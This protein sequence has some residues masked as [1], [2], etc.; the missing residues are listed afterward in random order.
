MSKLRYFYMESFGSVPLLSRV[1][2]E[3]K[4]AQDMVIRHIQKTYNISVQ[5]VINNKI[6]FLENRSNFLFEKKLGSIS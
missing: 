5:Q 3:L 2:P 6:I 4:N 1:H